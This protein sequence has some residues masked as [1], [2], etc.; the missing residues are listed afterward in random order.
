MTEKPSRERK[1]SQEFEARMGRYEFVRALGRGGM[2]EVFL[3]RQSGMAGFSKQLVIKRVL[4]ELLGDARFVEMFLDEARLAAR[5]TH[6]NICQVFELGEVK[7]QYF[8]AME[9]VAGVTLTH[10]V[11][12]ARDKKVAFP[13][14]PR[15]AS[16]LSSA[17]RS[18]TRT[19]SPTTRAARSTWCT[20]TSPPRT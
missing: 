16:W 20:A 5:L 14:P 11:L 4:P 2:A 17:R 13:S 12:Q 8:I 10:L 6:P 18:P 15:F 7:G 19:S 1:K 3:A 9:H